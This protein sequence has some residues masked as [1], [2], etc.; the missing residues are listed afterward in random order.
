MKAANFKVTSRLAGSVAVVYPQGYLNNLA[1]ESLVNESRGYIEK[2]IKNV[3]V[4]FRGT[5]LINSIGISLI[6][7]IMEELKGCGGR[8]CFSDMSKTHRDTFEMLGLTKFIDVFG[9]EEEAL[10]SL[11]EGGG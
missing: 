10:Q 6:L 9:T 4:N 11:G 2:G 3:V 1:G 5:D 8:L 7:H